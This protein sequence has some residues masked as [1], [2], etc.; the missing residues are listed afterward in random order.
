[1][2]ICIVL[3]DMEHFKNTPLNCLQIETAFQVQKAG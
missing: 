1:M 3:L 2:D